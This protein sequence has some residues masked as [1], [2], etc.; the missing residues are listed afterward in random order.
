MHSPLNPRAWPLVAALLSSGVTA[1]ALAAEPKKPTP[2]SPTAPAPAA[3]AQA[4][5]S[6]AAKPEDVA[7]PEALVA[8]LYDVISGPK[9]QARDWDRFRSLFAPGARMIPSGKRKDGTTGYR[10]ITPEEYITQSGKMLV[11]AGFRER[12]VHR[13]EERFGPLV[14][15]F[16]TYEALRGEDPKPFMRGVN[17]IQLVNDGKRWWV[18]TVAWTPESPEQPLPAKYLPPVK[19]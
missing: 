13:V 6:P 10:M 15:V 18:L 4:T 17:S 3:P 19:G 8:A 11:E 7:T 5:A 1:P 2:P 12:E 14:H 9:G 16:S